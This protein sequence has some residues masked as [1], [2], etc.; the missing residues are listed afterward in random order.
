[1]KLLNIKLFFTGIFFTGCFFIATNSKAQNWDINL[2]RSINPQDPNSVVWKGFT[3][4]AYPLSVAVPLGLWVDG[5]IEHNKKTE[6]NAYEIAGSVIIAAGATEVMKIIFDRARPY[7]TYTDVYPYKYEDG[8][9]FPSGHA[10]L[11]FA[12]ATSVSLIYK[13]WYVVVPAYVWAFGVGYSRLYLGAHYPTDVIGAAATGA[14][15]AL[16]SHWISKKIFK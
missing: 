5:K 8:K 3:S 1:M 9:S 16:L 15:S 11:A 12:T 7:Q 6:Y 14:G 2:L 10:S 4:S 13:K